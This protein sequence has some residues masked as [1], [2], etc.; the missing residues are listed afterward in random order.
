MIIFNFTIYISHQSY[1][2]ELFKF[3]ML[4]YL[5]FFQNESKCP[6]LQNP[7]HEGRFWN[8]W[9]TLDFHLSNIQNLT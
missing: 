3:K 2:V 6:Q 8:H 5:N 4:N 7:Q 9:Q 1:F